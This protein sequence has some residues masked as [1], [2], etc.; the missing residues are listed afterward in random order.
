MTQAYGY[1]T[2]YPY[3]CVIGIFHS[4]ADASGC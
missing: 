2:M 1:S 4:L 3:A